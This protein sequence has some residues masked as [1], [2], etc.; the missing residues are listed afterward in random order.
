VGIF[1]KF[2]L[3]ISRSGIYFGL[4]LG[5]VSVVTILLGTVLVHR[6]FEKEDRAYVQQSIGDTTRLLAAHFSNDLKHLTEDLTQ[7]AQNSILSQVTSDG[8]SKR[9]SVETDSDIL[10]VAIWKKSPRSGAFDFNPESIRVFLAINSRFPNLTT[11]AMTEIDQ[12]FHSDYPMVQMALNGRTLVTLPAQP[13]FRNDVALVVVP[14]SKSV[15]GVQ[16]VVAAHVVFSK[17][18]KSLILNGMVTTYLV[19]DF[20]NI[21]A[22]LDS[23]VVQRRNVIS[24]SPLF[25]YM[26]SSTL[27]S[28]Q[29]IYEDSQGRQ[30]FGGFARVSEGHLSVIAFLPVAEAI[31]G[32]VLLKKQS[33]LFLLASFFLFLGVGY[34]IATRQEPQAQVQGGLREEMA[35]KV[36]STILYGSLRNL[37]QM[38]EKETP[39]IAAETLNEFFAISA[40]TVRNYGGIFER[41]AGSSFMAIWGVPT[42][43]G[44]EVWKAIRCSLELRKNFL[45]VNASRRTDGQRA[46]SYGLGIHTGRGLAASIEVGGLMSY[47]VVGDMVNC[48]KALSHI[49]RDMK[50]DLLVSQESWQQSEAKFEGEPVGETQLTSQTGLTSIYKISGYR[51]E[52]GQ[53]VILECLQEDGVFAQEKH[54][55]STASS[56]IVKEKTSGRW[57]INNGSQIIGPIAPQ[58]ISAMLFS[59]ELDFDC[60]CW[61]EGTGDSAQIRD[62]FIFGTASDQQAKIWIYDGDLVHGPVTAGFLKTAVGHG[63]IS[64]SVF[65][66]EDTTIKGWRRLSELLPALFTVDSSSATDPNQQQKFLRESLAPPSGGGSGKLTSITELKTEEVPTSEVES[67]LKKAA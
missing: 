57:L 6:L 64:E 53:A 5:A 40:D 65:V 23:G 9:G 63:A 7:L 58:E 12:G 55:E 54:E 10:D 22:H 38:V 36:I 16:G 20:G 45:H 59:Q 44:T 18:E 21:V 50:V 61:S 1:S 31:Q 13:F 67:Q 43:D 15:E 14:L 52:Q 25:Q 32:A 42:S 3:S 8:L 35:Q 27:E 34:L 24:G 28:G 29:T 11:E 33:L 60:E 41:I 49:T 26:K 2:K 46:F 17:F 62:A 4:S 19:D 37:D 51:D 56:L 66:C 30:Y 39:E 47:T 48:A